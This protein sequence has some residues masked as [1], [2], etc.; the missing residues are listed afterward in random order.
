MVR[1]GA[2]A[3][4]RWAR[5][6]RPPWRCRQPWPSAAAAANR[7]RLATRAGLWWG[8]SEQLRAPARPSGC[9]S[10]DK[11]AQD[12]FRYSGDLRP[13]IPLPNRW[14]WRHWPESRPPSASIGTRGETRGIHVPKNRRSGRNRSPG[15]VAAWRCCPERGLRTGHYCLAVAKLTVDTAQRT[16]TRRRWWP[17]LFPLSLSASRPWPSRALPGRSR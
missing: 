16:S 12:T 4:I 15:T 6:S 9:S 7:E 8:R 13:T 2:D 5:R 11:S 1:P 14:R 10:A 17:Q 3:T